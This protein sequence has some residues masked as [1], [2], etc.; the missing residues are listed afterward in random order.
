MISNV[1]RGKGFALAMIAMASVGCFYSDPINA[2]PRAEI[3]RLAPVDGPA[4]KGG[5]LAFEASTTTDPDG[6]VL[7][8][9]WTVFACTGDDCQTELETSTQPILRHRLADKRRRRV[10][11][12][13]RDGLG[14]RARASVDVVVANRPPLVT[15]TRSD[16]HLGGDG[17]FTAGRTIRFQAASSDPDE[18]P[19]DVMWKL[20]PPPDSDPTRRESGS[21]PGGG[22]FVRTDVPGTWRVEVAAD[23]GD[24]GQDTAVVETC[25]SAD[26]APCLA[27]VEPAAPPGAVVIVERSA[28]P[29]HFAVETVTDDL[30]VFPLPGSA[31]DPELGASHFRWALAPEGAPLPILAGSDSA[32]LVF[33]PEAFAPSTRLTVRVEV[34]DRRLVWPQCGPSESACSAAGNTCVQRRSW[35]VEVR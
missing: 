20:T 3:R 8:V 10:V 24:G 12:E 22:F 35:T 15:L 29:V 34:A 31:G 14:A 16:A 19:V 17:C 2:R 13:V 27:A 26:R 1:Q 9:A 7:E 30:D 11:L 21:L 25:V 33:D 18:D 32:A 23:D 28:G 5:E 6:E 4:H